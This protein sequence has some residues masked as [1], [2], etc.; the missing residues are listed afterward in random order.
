MEV[1][2]SNLNFNVHL[3]S[4]VDAKEERAIPRSRY[5]KG[6]TERRARGVAARSVTAV[7]G[8][9]V[10]SSSLLRKWDQEQHGITFAQQ[11]TESYTPG[12][13]RP[14]PVFYR[15]ENWFNNLLQNIYQTGKLRQL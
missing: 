13:G 12:A 8:C 1:P 3:A 10:S 14:T 7:I 11:A 5:T 6:I 4:L 15:K 2:H 9:A